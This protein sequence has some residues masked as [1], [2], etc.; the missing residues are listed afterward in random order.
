MSVS[1]ATDYA[2]PTASDAPTDASGDH[3]SGQAS[4]DQPAASGHAVPHAVE[5]SGLS[6]TFRSGNRSH[7]ALDDVALTVAPGEMV[8]LIGASGSGKSTLLRH[9]SGLI[10]ADRKPGTRV[11]VGGRKVQHEHGIAGGIREVRCGVGFIFQQFNL[12]GRLTLLKNVCLGMIGRVPSYRSLLGVFTHNEKRLAMAAL[13]RVGMARYAGQRA[14]TLSGGQQQ[15]AAIARAMV[16]GA[17]VLLADEPIASLDPASAT[18]VMQALSELNRDGVTVLVCLHQVEYARRY[19]P[20]T[21]ALSDGEIVFDGDT[22]ELTNSALKEL[23]GAEA[24]DAC[25]TDAAAARDAA[26][27]HDEDT[28]QPA[29]N[30]PVAPMVEV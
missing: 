4:T 28:S 18:K 17:G 3:A 26:A 27:T 1:T 10:P 2:E 15:R 20:R 23:Y 21:V 9:L 16:Q 5:V 11:M 25:F 8:A 29:I 24:E 30:H 19:C 14:S 6:K 22:A 13:E 7:R 12:V